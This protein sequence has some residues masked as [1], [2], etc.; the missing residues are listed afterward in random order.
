MLK[1]RL[2]R[3]SRAIWQAYRERGVVGGTRYVVRAVQLKF[4]LLLKHKNAQRH[5]VELIEA[6]KNARKNTK[7]GTTHMALVI[8]GG[9]GDLIVIA[10]LMR[11]IA[12]EAGPIRFDVF[13]KRPAICSWLFENVPGFAGAHYDSL[14]DAMYA[15][16]DVALRANSFI[17]TYADRLHWKN[18]CQNKRMA[19][20]VFALIYNRNEF[21]DYVG[22][23][24]Y[25]DNQLA[26]AIV[27]GGHTR[28]DYVHHLAGIPY[29]GDQLDIPC[30]DEALAKYGLEGRTYVTVHNGFDADFIITGQVATKCYPYFGKV[31]AQLRVARPDILFVQLGTITS[32]AIPECELNLINQTSLV[33]VASIIKGAAL[34]L[35]NEGGLVHLATCLGTRSVVVFGPTPSDYFGYASNVNIDP[36][37]CGDCWWTARSWMD[38]C[39]E[40]YSEVR[41]MTEQKPE[42]VAAK[43]LAALPPPA[44]VPVTLPAALAKGGA[45]GAPMAVLRSPVR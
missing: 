23:H 45:M 33:E 43:T 36:P 41:C 38:K 31:V 19:E 17:V 42:N 29:G 35:D 32:E 25:R 37:V 44:P 3:F 24:P 2:D 30:S 40:A 8:T 20:L 9:I 10:R 7:P 13:V 5:S 22:P 27:K 26:R 21:D 16:Y 18:I 14:F 15:H 6:L 34:H 4:T 28:R 1:E 11:D 39:P 12:A